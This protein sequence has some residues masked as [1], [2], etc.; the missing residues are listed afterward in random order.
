MSSSRQDRMT[1]ICAKLE[2]RE[3]GIVS[4][5]GRGDIDFLLDEVSRVHTLFLEARAE[6]AR[7]ALAHEEDGE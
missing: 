5:L 3:G 4:L 1:A 7:A 2:N 6:L